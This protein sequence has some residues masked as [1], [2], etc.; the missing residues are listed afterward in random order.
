MS[1]S[2]SLTLAK[3]KTL[4]LLSTDACGTVDRPQLRGLTLEETRYVVDKNYSN[5]RYA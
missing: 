5:S 3:K 4:L 2:L 1:Q